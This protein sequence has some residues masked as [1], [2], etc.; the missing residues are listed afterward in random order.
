MKLINNTFDLDN[1]Q[2]Y[3][4]WRYEKL[5]N[6][7]TQ[8]EQLIVEVNDPLNLT[9]TERQAI[10]NL[11]NKTNMVVYVSDSGTNPDKRLALSLA[12]K[13]GLKNLDNNMGADDDGITSL[14]VSNIKGRER[15]IPYS[16]KEIHWHTDGYYN[17]LDKQIYALN[18]H[19][20]RP[21]KSGGENA[22][23]DHELAYIRLRDQNPDYIKALMASDVMTIPANIKDGKTIRPDRKGP[24]FSIWGDGNLHMRYTAR[25]HNV[26]WKDD[27]ITQAAVQALDNLLK[28]D[29]PAIFRATLQPGW[30]LISNNV[31]HDRSGFEDDKEAPRLLYRLRYFDALSK[32]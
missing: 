11:Y 23:M 26:I 21:A 4:D 28:S 19:C 3:E 30:G 27:S 32:G 12:D 24:V 16:N 31:L 29:D 14:Q 5:D 22:I 17:K 25:A 9:T 20:V 10:I 15:Y 8:V 18:L 1:H 6:Y 2:A 7:P 13:F